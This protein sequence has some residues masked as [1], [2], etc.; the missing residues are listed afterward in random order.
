MLST[1]LIVFREVLEAALVVSIV[2]AA[3]KGVLNRGWWVSGGLLGGVVGAGLIALF[4]DVI[5]SWASGMGQEVF[6]A[7]VM[8][9]A[10]VMLAWHSIWMGKHSREMAQQI[11]SVGKAVAAG[12]RPLTGLAIVVGVA[13]LREGSE[14]VLF[15]YGIAA[16]DPGQ[17]P[18]M[19]VGGLL[20]IVGGV[21]LGAAMY[22]GLL[23]IPL[24]RLFA[25]TNALII[26][27]AAGMAS[28]GV[29]YLASAGIL[30]SWGDTVWDTS[31]LL[32]ESSVVGK[33]LHTLIGYTAR[34]AGIQIV[35]W[36]ATLVVIMLLA[37]AVGRPQGAAGQSRQS[38]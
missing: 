13:V 20:G 37:R 9:I 38:A 32:K 14:A 21:G 28:Q 34:P 10:V 1:A 5:S 19:I 6:N 4:A 36:L 16:G 24:K 22:A 7:C 29:G 15:L 30:P 8:F 12:S 27:L 33:M 3:T 11:S 25:V 2:M 35:A 26:L 23:Q 17:T 18:Q 31:W